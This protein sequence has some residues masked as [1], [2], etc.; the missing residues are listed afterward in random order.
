M[1]LAK[2]CPIRIQSRPL[3]YTCTPNQRTLSALESISAKFRS[4]QL[5]EKSSRSFSN[6][7]AANPLNVLPQILTVK[8]TDQF[9]PSDCP[10]CSSYRPIY[11]IEFSKTRRGRDV[12]A[13]GV[14]LLKLTKQGFRS[15][16]RWLFPG[17]IG[18]ARRR[19]GF[20]MPIFFQAES[21]L[22]ESATITGFRGLQSFP[23]R[24]DF[25]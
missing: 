10:L 12:A 1:L 13:D 22:S 23:E 7:T 8:W 5:P 11:S 3:T 17:D 25:L 2:H 14:F 18:C 21:F 9:Y 20:C 6:L 19:F 15:A 24:F 16:R 4:R